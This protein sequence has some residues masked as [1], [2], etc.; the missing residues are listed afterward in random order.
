MHDEAAAWVARLDGREPAAA[1]RATFDDWIARDPAHAAAYAEALRTW[2]DLA[3]MRGSEQYRA[4]LGTPTLRER[5]VSALRGPRWAALAVGVAAIVAF[6]WLG[7]SLDVLPFLHRPTQVA[8][9]LAEVREMTLPD[10]TRIVLGAQSQIDFLV[11]GK[12]RHATVISGDAFFAVAHDATRPFVVETG[13]YTVR[14]LGT[15][16]EIRRRPDTVR[17]AVSEGRVAVKRVDMED[18]SV[19]MSGAAWTA[20]SGG[21]EVRPVDA[22]DVGAW[23]SGRLVYDNAA[24]RDIVADANRYTRS[25]IVV[26]DPQLETLRLTTSFRTSQVD[27]MVETLQAALPLVA[28]R[29]ANGDILLRAR[30]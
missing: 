25:H 13:D 1:E 20:G 19:L 24:L 30:P 23:R 12:T 7:F 28:E 3:A 16:F 11:T 18:A 22:M 26:V 4:L 8:T 2:R 9:Q 15:Q 27:G 6:V 14:V 17:V 5:M 10:G 21:V 29:R